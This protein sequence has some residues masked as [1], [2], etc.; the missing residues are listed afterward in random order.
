MCAA[1]KRLRLLR[2]VLGASDGWPRCDSEQIR[3]QLLARR[4]VLLLSI[5]SASALVGTRNCRRAPVSTE[6]KYA[7]SNGVNI[8]YQVVGEGPL[9][10]VFVMG[11]VSNLDYFWEEPHV[12]RFLRRLA[13]FSRLILFDK[14]GTGLSD[15]VVGVPGLEERMDDLRAVMDGVGSRRRAP[16]PVRSR[17]A[18]LA[19]CRDV[20]RARA[21]P[22]ADR[23]RAAP[24]L[25]ARLSLGRDR[26]RPGAADRGDRARLGQRAGRG[27]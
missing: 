8:A 9:D 6:T 4:N 10:L 20:S 18:V 5:P 25:G 11:W 3:S 17:R 12:A 19:V 1:S 7:N 23:V 27:L 14:R 21:R 22:G 2:D 16:W 24:A 26:R 13:S 15:R